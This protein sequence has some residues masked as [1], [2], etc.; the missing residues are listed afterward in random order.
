MRSISILCERKLHPTLCHPARPGVP[1]DR[2]RISY[3]AAPKMTS[4]CRQETAHRAGKEKTI[5]QDCRRTIASL[6]AA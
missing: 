3:H 2:T 1:W 6:D 4:F 5:G